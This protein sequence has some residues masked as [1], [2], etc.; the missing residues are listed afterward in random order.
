MTGEVNTDSTL[1][2][3]TNMGEG[4]NSFNAVFDADTFQ[5]DDDGG[6]FITGAH[7]GGAAH[8]NV[9]ASSGNDMISFKSIN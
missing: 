1:N 5:I 6:Q 3:N 7:L 4:N 2:F 9:E 8:F